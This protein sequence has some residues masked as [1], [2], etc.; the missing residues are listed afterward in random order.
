MGYIAKGAEVNIEASLTQK[1][2]E[3]LLKGNKSDLKVA[4]FG[5]GDSDTNYLAGLRKS[6][7]VDITGDDSGCIK[8][9][10]ASI[11]IKNNVIL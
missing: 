2:R 7:V 9:I 1:G 3:I 10:S 6:D 8:S 11:S 4:Y 5:L